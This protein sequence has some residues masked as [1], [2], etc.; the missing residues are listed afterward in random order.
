[1]PLIFLLCSYMTGLNVQENVD[2]FPQYLF[3][4]Q[5][6]YIVFWKLGS[7]FKQSK[8]ISKRE[9][10]QIRLVSRFRQTLYFWEI[11]I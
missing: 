4:P 11:Y 6:P 5:I 8:D 10:S 9:L 3:L 2:T 1:M 7:N